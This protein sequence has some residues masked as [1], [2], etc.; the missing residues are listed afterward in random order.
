MAAKVICPDCGSMDIRRSDPKNL[1]ERIYGLSGFTPYF[2]EECYLRFFAKLA[3]NTPEAAAETRAKGPT[4]R[5]VFIGAGLLVVLAVGLGLGLL[6]SSG[7]S[8]KA[9]TDTAPPDQSTESPPTHGPAS[10]TLAAPPTTVATVIIPPSTTATTTAKPAVVKTTLRPTPPTTARLPKRPSSAAYTVQLAAFAKKDMADKLAAKLAAR[11]IQT[12]VER[13]VNPDG[14]VWF[15]VR[16]GHFATRK[17]AVAHAQA[18]S[19]KSGVKAFVA[20]ARKQ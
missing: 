9:S 14:K 16:T 8:Q 1:W 10:D 12:R 3:R 11:G 4:I 17:Q 18:L 13:I 15:K 7:T 19:R 2:C 20:P 5:P 6:Q